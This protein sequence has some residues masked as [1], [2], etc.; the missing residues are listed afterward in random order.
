MDARI[1]AAKSVFIRSHSEI[2]ILIQLDRN[3][4]KNGFDILIT[5]IHKLTSISDIHASCSYSIIS[6]DMSHILYINP[7]NRS[8]R[9]LNEQILATAESIKSNTSCSYFFD[10]MSFANST[11]VSVISAIAVASELAFSQ[12]GNIA[13]TENAAVV[14]NNVEI[15]PVLSMTILDASNLQTIQNTLWLDTIKLEWHSD[16]SEIDS[17]DLKHEFREFKPLQLQSKDIEDKQFDD[18]KWD[19]NSKFT[20]YQKWLWTK[21]LRKYL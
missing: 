20:R 21:I 5:P 9:I 17:M 7:S 8:V 4:K 13:A 14:K 16:V 1:F 2:F 3:L 11:I 15:K 12:G 10:V 19:I 6:S 18:L